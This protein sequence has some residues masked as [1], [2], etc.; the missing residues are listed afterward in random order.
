MG[1]FWTAILVLW[2]A[3][4][5]NGIATLDSSEGLGYPLDYWCVIELNA[6]VAGQGPYMWG[7]YSETYWEDQYTPTEQCDFAALETFTYW[8]ETQE[9]DP[10]APFCDF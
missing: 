9:Q 6:Q 4:Y 8:C 5:P 2:Q 1:T 10:E 3:A 7:S